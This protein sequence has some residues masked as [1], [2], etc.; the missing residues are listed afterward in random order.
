MQ[1]MLTM[2][3]GM[4]EPQRQMRHEIDCNSSFSVSQQLPTERFLSQSLAPQSSR[5]DSVFYTPEETIPARRKRSMSRSRES[6]QHQEPASTRRRMQ[7]TS[8][9]SVASRLQT[10]IR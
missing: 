1:T 4:K 2:L 8:S 10:Q 9:Q 7:E 3:Q 6:S 5:H